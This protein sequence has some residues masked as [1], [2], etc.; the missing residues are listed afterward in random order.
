MFY[1]TFLSLC[2]FNFLLKIDSNILYEYGRFEVQSDLIFVSFI[3]YFLYTT[4]YLLYFA[5]FAI[6]VKSLGFK[7]IAV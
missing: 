1:I 6:L 3:W 2:S 5:L 7:S 4:P